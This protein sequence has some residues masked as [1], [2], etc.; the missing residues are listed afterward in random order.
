MVVIN[1]CIVA[2]GTYE[3]LSYVLVDSEGI[4]A[5]GMA[6]N[7]CRWLGPMASMVYGLRGGD[8][9]DED[10]A[11]CWPRV[12]TFHTISFCNACFLAN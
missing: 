3:K 7:T 2:V 4:V 12:S 5:S 10:N 6:L 9:G 8:F 1:T 11:S